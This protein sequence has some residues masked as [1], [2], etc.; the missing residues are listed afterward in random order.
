MGAVDEKIVVWGAKPHRVKVSEAISILTG[1]PIETDQLLEH[2][3]PAL[4]GMNKLHHTFFIGD[5][6]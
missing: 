2:N 1:F 4:I 6:V 5:I 3:R